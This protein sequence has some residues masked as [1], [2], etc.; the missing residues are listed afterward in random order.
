MFIGVLKQLETIANAYL[1][2]L[3]DGGVQLTLQGDDDADRIVKAVWVRSADGTMRERGLSQLSGGQWRR[4]SMALD[5]AFAEIIRRRG[6][7]RSNLIVMDEV[8]THLDASGREAVGSVLRAMV[9]GPR[10][11][12]AW[13]DVDDEAATAT[14]ETRQLGVADADPAAAAAAAA[15]GI[16]NELAR[17]LLGGGAYETAIVILQDLSAMEL[18]EAFD[19]VDIVVKAADTSKVII[20]GERG[21]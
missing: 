17:A 13:P 9:D 4:V 8:L 16:S 7:L 15:A 20:D 5:L 19:H 2:V 1:Q 6:T 11:G 21:Q 14:G 10:A 12:E 18:E 3:A